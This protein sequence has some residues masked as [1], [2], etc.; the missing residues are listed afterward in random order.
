MLTEYG[1]VTV[2]V[3]ALPAAQPAGAV[4]VV[5]TVV[6]QLSVAQVLP[7]AIWED[8]CASVVASA[9]VYAEPSIEARRAAARAASVTVM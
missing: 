3:T 4:G 7:E 9:Y 2:A 8:C 6:H 1:A 5:V